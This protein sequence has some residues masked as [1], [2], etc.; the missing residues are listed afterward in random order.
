M[1]PGVAAR[2]QSVPALE[3]S[4]RI[5][6]AIAQSKSGLTL[7]ELVRMTGLPKSSVHCILL[8]LQRMGYLYRNA[9]TSRFLFGMKMVSLANTGMGG[10]KLREQS[11]PFLQSLSRLTGL[12]V[13]LAILEHYEPVIVGRAEAAGMVKIP[14]WIGKRMAMHCTALGK[15]LLCDSSDD[16]L[17]RVVRE[18]G[19]PRHN[20]NTLYSLSKLKADLELTRQRGHSVDDEEDEIGVRCVGVPVMDGEGQVVAAISV[21]GSTAQVRADNIEDLGRRLK[22]TA[23][24]IS[25]AMAE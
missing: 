24:A 10:F 19:M 1:A 15:A 21:S 2:T 16:A 7:L 13:H 22:V 18:R 5:L 3:K 6:E 9:R 8:T 17:E 4:F 20:E 23:G 14:T 11:Q 25:R 12:T